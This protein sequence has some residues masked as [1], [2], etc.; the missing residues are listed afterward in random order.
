MPYK[1]YEEML[2]AY[3]TGSD[4]F[5]SAAINWIEAVDKTPFVNEE[6][7]GLFFKAK[8]YC[9]NWRNGGIDTRS[10]KRNMIEM[11]R[12]IADMNLPNPHKPE[13][14]QEATKKQEIKTEKNEVE[15]KKTEPQENKIESKEKKVELKEDKV[16]LK[17]DKV[18]LIADTKY[19]LLAMAKAYNE[20]NESN[21]K[22]FAI[23]LMDITKEN[24]FVQGT[25]EFEKFEEMIVAYK[26]H[27]MRR[28]FVV[29]EQLCDIINNVDITDQNQNKRQTILGVLPDEEKEKKTWFK[30]LHPWKE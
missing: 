19:V 13:E 20:K 17:E 7:R 27:N 24:P 18:E 16:E 29:A 14:V 8:K 28:L 6:A 5:P 26:K 15:I 23:Y 30:F 3:K 25:D 10:A 1:L 21:F 22:Q 4:T 9:R 2:E 12:K 11:A